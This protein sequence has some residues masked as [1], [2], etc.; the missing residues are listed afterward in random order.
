MTTPEPTRPSFAPGYGIESTSHGLLTWEWVRQRLTESRSYWL[1]TTRADGKPHAAPVWGVW[2]GDTLYFG[3]DFNS[4]K[5]RNLKSRPDSV[6]HL[7]SGDE[8]VILEGRAEPVTDATLLQ[9][10]SGLYGSKYGVT[11]DFADPATP[12]FCFRVQRAFAWREQ[13]FPHTATRWQFT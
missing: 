11:P 7:E 2:T 4:V 9:H 6:V 10:V 3:T 5:G 1:A 13:D 12:A 8:A